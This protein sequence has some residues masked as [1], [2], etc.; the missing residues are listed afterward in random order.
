M[1]C[2]L[3]NDQSLYTLKGFF[4]QTASSSTKTKAKETF[5]GYLKSYLDYIIASKFM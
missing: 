5:Y 4:I 1:S 3:L 2:E